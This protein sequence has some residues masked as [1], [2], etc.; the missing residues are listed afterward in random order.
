MKVKDL[1][2]DYSFPNFH[3]VIR[4]FSL[5]QI[6][7]D[8]SKMSAKEYLEEALKEQKVSHFI[9]LKKRVSVILSNQKI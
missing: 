2:G 1:A 4:D 5:Q 9:F 7:T 6:R 3:W 8:G